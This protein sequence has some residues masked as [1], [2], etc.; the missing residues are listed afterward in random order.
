MFIN[1]YDILSRIISFND[2]WMKS[3]M[4]SRSLSIA[5]IQL[6]NFSWCNHFSSDIY[7]ENRYI[8]IIRNKYWIWCQ[9]EE[10]LK[11]VD[12]ICSRISHGIIES[13]WWKSS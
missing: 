9:S 2:H 4:I 8:L 13:I 10:Y 6:T 12:I 3:L 1:D 7:D 5:R 11:D